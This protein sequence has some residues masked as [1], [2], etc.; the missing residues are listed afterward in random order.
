MLFAA[1]YVSGFIIVNNYLWQ[2]RIT[3]LEFFQPPFVAA[4]LLFVI[5]EIIAGL[6]ALPVV[7]FCVSLIDLSETIYF[8]HEHE[9]RSTVESPSIYQKALSYFVLISGVLFFWALLRPFEASGTL[10][11]NK[12]LGF[13]TGLEG[14][15]PNSY[16]ILE[17]MMLVQGVSTSLILT[18]SIVWKKINRLVV[19]LALTLASL[20]FIFVQ[21]YTLLQF[22]S[23]LYKDLPIAFG[24]GKP[25]TV[26]LLIQADKLTIDLLDSVGL[27][28]EDFLANEDMEIDTGVKL[29][30]TQPVELIWQVS[31][32][33]FNSS[34]DSLSTYILRYC[35]EDSQQCSVIELRRSIVHGMIHV[36]DSP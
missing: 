10:I 1:V 4:G 27:P 34:N 33:Q 32:D 21:I 29:I 26:I 9:L 30:Q 8:G 6:I 20:I 23:N 16:R 15:D 28:V 2:F 31:N 22:S 35:Q 12:L 13:S 36:S 24:G 25:N 5:V 3:H 18:T 19:I 14:L 7:F 11:V 17:T